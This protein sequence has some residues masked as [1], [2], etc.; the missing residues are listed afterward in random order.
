MA[1]TASRAALRRKLTGRCRSKPL[2]SRCRHHSHDS[3]IGSPVDAL[4]EEEPQGRS[5]GASTQFLRSTTQA[6][7]S[8]EQSLMRFQLANF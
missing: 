8:N 1:S 7:E 6:I 3:D 5:A 4:H 2:L